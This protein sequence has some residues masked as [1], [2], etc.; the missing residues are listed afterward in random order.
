MSDVPLGAMLSGGLDSSLVVG[1]MARHMTEPVKTFS[2]GF[3]EAGAA[4]ELDDAR[5]V[6]A[7]FGADHH[8]LELSLSDREVDLADLVWHLDEPLAD[9]SSL[10]FL[11]L[12]ELAARHVTVALS[13]QGADELLGGYS[14][15]RNAT[16]VDAWLGTP[17]PIRRI[18][19]VLAGR[20]PARLRKAGSLVA[21]PDMARRL[22][23]TKEMI[24][25]SLR[26]ALVRDQLA[27]VDG[28][29]YRAVRAITDEL[30]APTLPSALYLDTR[31]SLVDDMLHYF[32]RASMA[33]SL[34]VRVP[35]LDHRVV[36][37][38]ATIPNDLKVRRLTTKYILK[39]AARGLVPDRI[40][41]KRK[42][43]F[44]NQ[45]IGAWIG[46]QID[47]AV[48]DYLLAPEPRYAELLD[49]SGVEA[50]VRAHGSGRATRADAEAV[51]TILMLEVWLS[52]FLPRAV[53]VRTERRDVVD[54]A[55]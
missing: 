35:F 53:P 34:E 43:G 23:S 46:G 31:L 9:L 54:L 44:F 24:P 3:P 50:L 51:L 2:V 16:L 13:G 38:C 49:R 42:I 27:A 17:S 10:G 1:L 40:I 4:N 32:D 55:R 5:F 25:D 41:D 37:Y 15:H 39:R 33:R 22:L 8:E 11:A 48:A 20:G 47:G 28:A 18:A 19:L 12:S 30:T 52:S 14:R 6:A 45:S 26:R 29:G 7:H 21:E 36:E